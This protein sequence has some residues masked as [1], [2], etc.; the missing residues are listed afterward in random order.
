MEKN[1]ITEQDIRAAK[2]SIPLTLKWALAEY[3]AEFCL[4]KKHMTIKEN[5]VNTIPLPDMSQRNTLREAQYKIGV[6]VKEYLGK[7]YDPVHDSDDEPIPYLMAADDADSWSNFESQLDR[8]KRSKDKAVADKC[9]DM[10]NDYHAFVRMVSIEIENELQVKNDLLGRAAWFLSN[11][12]GNLSLDDLKNSIS[13]LANA[14][15]Q[16]EE[17]GEEAPVEEE[18]VTEE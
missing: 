2:A 18:N 13:E 5:G 7:E 3:I 12:V 16:P 14:E 9:Y 11:Y 4:D 1:I 17:A 15:E 6:F 8:L 10:L